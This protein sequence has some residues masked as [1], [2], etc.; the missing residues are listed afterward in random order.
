MRTPLKAGDIVLTKDYKSHKI[1]REAPVGWYTNIWNPNGYFEI[2][3]EC[4][5][6]DEDIFKGPAW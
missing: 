4:I 1:V 6:Y 3:R 5:I 2:E